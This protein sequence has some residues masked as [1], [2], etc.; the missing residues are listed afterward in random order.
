VLAGLVSLALS[1]VL[2]GLA[3]T[4]PAMLAARIV[5]GISSAF[6]WTSVFTWCVERSSAGRRDH[7]GGLIFGAGFAGVTLGPTL[8]AL[9]AQ[10]GTGT[11]FTGFAIVVALLIPPVALA[12]DGRVSAPGRTGGFL[13][14]ARSTSVAVAL[15]L[16]ALPGFLSGALGLLLTLRLA[17]L[18]A[19]ARGIAA[20]FVTAAIVQGASSVAI[21]RWSARRDA[22]RPALAAVVVAA[23][24]TAS[25]IAL[26]T[27]WLVSAALVVIYA[28]AAVLL[29][30]ATSLLGTAMARSG[31]PTAFGYALMNLAFAPGSI[32][33]SLAAGAIRQD[34]GQAPALVMVSVVCLCTAIPLVGGL[35]VRA[36]ARA[37]R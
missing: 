35:T 14:F 27:I 13:A 5:G 29:V 33:G 37:R 15:T 8:G 32:V 30:T 36:A 22:R 19:G 25:V 2:F 17:G 12:R 7:V 3:T 6:S 23:G 24:L 18:G 34:A 10:V 4:F 21:G 26:R 20:A 28:A 1:G 16:Q 31:H 9:A 11:V